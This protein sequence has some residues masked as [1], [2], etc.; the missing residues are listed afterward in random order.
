MILPALIGGSIVVQVMYII[1][2]MYID[3]IHKIYEYSPEAE[4]SLT[5]SCPKTLGK[6]SLP[7]LIANLDFSSGSSL[8][9]R[10]FWGISTKKICTQSTRNKYNPLRAGRTISVSFPIIFIRKK[11]LIQEEVSDVFFLRV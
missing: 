9:E 10:Y 1:F 4:H 7:F 2:Y 6:H 3:H 11:C 5:N 8:V